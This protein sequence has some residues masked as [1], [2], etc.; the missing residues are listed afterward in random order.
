MMRETKLKE[1]EM[2]KEFNNKRRIDTQQHLKILERELKMMDIEKEREIRVIAEEERARNE[3]YLCQLKI[4]QELIREN[5]ERQFRIMLNQE[6]EFKAQKN[7]EILNK[8]REEQG[9]QAAELQRQR[10]ENESL[11]RQ[12]EKKAVDDKILEMRQE[13]AEIS[14]KKEK[15]MQETLKKIEE[16][17]RIQQKT[18]QELEYRRKELK[19]RTAYQ[20]VIQ[21]NIEE[22]MEKERSN[23]LKFQNDIKKETSD[24]ELQRKKMHEKKMNEILRQREETLLQI[25][26]PKAEFNV[27]DR[28]QDFQQYSDEEYEPRYNSMIRVDHDDENF[29]EKQEVAENSEKSVSFDD[30]FQERNHQKHLMNTKNPK[31]NEYYNMYVKKNFQAKSEDKTQNFEITEQSED[32]F[33]SSNKNNN[34]FR[35]DQK[36]KKQENYDPQ[37]FESKENSQNKLIKYAEYKTKKQEDYDPQAFDFKE[38]SINKLS[39]YAEYKTEKIDYNE[40]ESSYKEDNFSGYEK[41]E[42][43]KTPKIEEFERYKN[44]K[45]DPK[46]AKIASSL[47]S[48]E[49]RT[50]PEYKKLEPSK[51]IY[52]EKNFEKPSVYKNPEDYEPTYAKPEETSQKTKKMAEQIIKISEESS[53]LSESKSLNSR[54]KW[55]YH[56]QSSNSSIESSSLSFNQNTSPKQ[57]DFYTS[58]TEKSNRE[59]SD[60]WE[61]K[62]ESYSSYNSHECSSCIYS[63][64]EHSSECSCDCSS[65]ESPPMLSPGHYHYSSSDNSEDSYVRRS[66]QL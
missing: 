22:T 24:L 19:E 41:I 63:N 23:F 61:E 15:M 26:S 44:L 51:G 35:F 8:I 45:K 64:S 5:D 57:E 47:D 10:E 13:S 37:A 29:Y 6:K 62:S 43:N 48:F 55:N 4:K 17:R 50:H 66:T 7:E 33:S 2:T 30:E 52:Q 12:L 34:K 14:K 1:I 36:T 28:I 40:E 58:K 27:K 31:E 54:K 46:E 65:E 59:Y 20:Q 16:D 39:K 60:Q 21:N 56:S 49:F 53:D 3:E 32:S 38:N 11:E 9:K 42:E 18:Q 25:T